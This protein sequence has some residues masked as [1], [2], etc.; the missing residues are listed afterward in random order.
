[1][2]L[3]GV[4][5]NMTIAFD[6]QMSERRVTRAAERLIIGCWSRPCR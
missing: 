6:P 4:N 2:R 3:T 1:M 5:L